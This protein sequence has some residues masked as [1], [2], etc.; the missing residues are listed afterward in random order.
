VE[1]RSAF[2]RAWA[3]LAGHQVTLWSARAA[4]IGAAIL[5]TA[6]LGVLA[7]FVDL[8][9]S[10]GRVPSGHDLAPTQQMA[11]FAALDEFSGERRT[12][13]L[14]AVGVPANQATKINGPFESLPILAREQ[15]WR[16]YVWDMLDTRVSPVA[17]ATYADRVVNVDKDP[18]YAVGGLG[19]LS[20]VVRTHGLAINPTIG[21]LAGWN[22]WAWRPDD[23]R[24]PNFWYLTGLLFLAVAL[25][26]LRAVLLNAM[27]FAASAAGVIVAVRLRRSLYH[28]T[29]RL[30][31]LTIR[32]TGPGEAAT[33]FNRHVEI[34]QDAVQVRLT[35][36]FF[37]PLEM[38][39]LVLFALAIH[40]WLALAF[41]LAAL[42]VLLWGGQIAT[43]LRQAG[44]SADRRAAARMALLQESLMI[45]RL[46][47]SNVM[48]LFNQSRV[49]R[50][51]SDYAAARLRRARGE[52]L[53]RPLL[54]FLGTLSAAVLL[55]VSGMIVL[56]AGLGTANV[57]VL[58]ATL[59]AAYWPLRDWLNSRRRIHRGQESA[60]LI[61]EFLDRPRE[62]GQVVGAEFLPGVTKGVEFRAVG[63]RDPASGRVLLDDVTMR[64]AAGERVGL[65]GTDPA[66][67]HAVVFLLARFL[68]PTSGEIRIDD[69]NLKWLTLDSIRAQIA[70]VLQP[71]LIFNDTVANNIGCGDPSYAVPQII[72]AAKIAH[73]HQFIQK[74]PYGYETPVGEMGSSLR[75]GEQ[76]RIA[77]ARAILRDP[78]MY[79]I[80][81]PPTP[82]D[83]DTKDL[84][85]DT[86]TRILP[87]KTVLFMPHRI[88]TIRSCDRV[89]LIH[90]GRVEAAGDHHQL[91][92]GND[93]Y[94]HVH[95]L[96]FNEFAGQT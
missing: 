38:T 80:E 49:E 72:E 31:T 79:V 12:T 51:L 48:E 9:I 5:T 66:E 14:E 63:L 8:L 30:G 61:Y 39:F 28:H 10:R 88:S 22:S 43:N 59:T 96:E 91:I 20:L 34:V 69:K 74:L 29:Y 82:L 83:D 42:L 67:T 36:Q 93:L 70:V 95:Y 17:A 47:K 6:L 55:Y 37:C 81:E 68:D 52:A 50:Q 35:L 58:A 57:N 89:F 25:A 45:M 11:F 1:Y 54:W 56:S 78:A 3:Y 44:R 92:A 13:A 41:I 4:G 15:L 76:F 18:H 19:V 71:N 75:I 73:A 77:L 40:F 21:R 94:K 53:F 16:A 86:F 84:L 85:D 23:A 62:V 64:I 90:R 32:S 87:G 46:V 33:L 60:V 65:I 2:T 27:S 7:L 24:P 26:L